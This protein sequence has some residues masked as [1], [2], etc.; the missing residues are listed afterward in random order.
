[1]YCFNYLSEVLPNLCHC[2]SNHSTMSSLK[3]QIL[4]A[5]P[6]SKE[7]NRKQ[8]TCSQC[9]G[10]FKSHINLKRHISKV[11]LKNEEKAFR[12]ETCDRKYSY[13]S[14]LNLHLRNAHSNKTGTFQCK[15]CSK[16][17]GN[18]QAL[19][20]HVKR[21]HERIK[22]FKCNCCSMTFVQTNN[23]HA[24]QDYSCSLLELRSYLLLVNL[25][26]F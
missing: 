18:E 15:S 25:N 3:D 6:K 7:E 4:E 19:K 20:M 24:V 17:F 8:P 13:K 9:S 22:D 16:L 2:N 1:M 5:H 11:H 21:I 23:S 26:K 14:N 12:C 10:V